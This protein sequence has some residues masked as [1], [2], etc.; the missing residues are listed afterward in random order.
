LSATIN[1]LKVEHASAFYWYQLSASVS[2]AQHK[3]DGTSTD[4][5]KLIVKPSS[6]DLTEFH[7]CSSTDV[8]VV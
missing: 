8:R 5:S 4:L 7:N 2:I 3:L 1:N 6:V